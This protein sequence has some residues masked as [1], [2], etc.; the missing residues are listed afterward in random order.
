MGNVGLANIGQD[1]LNLQNPALLPFNRNVNIEGGYHLQRKFFENEVSSSNR[2]G[3]G[4][5]HLSI[6]LPLTKK[7]TAAFGIKPFSA[8]EYKFYAPVSSPF[9]TAVSI[10][11]FQKMQ[12]TLS[13]VFLAGGVQLAK[14]FNIGMEASYIFGTFTQTDSIIVAYQNF[15]GSQY[16]IDR[17]TLFKGLM[18]RPGFSYVVPINKEKLTSLVI[19]GTVQMMPALQAKNYETAFRPFGIDTINAGTTSS[20]QYPVNYGLGIAFQRSF[21]FRLAGD[22]KYIAASGRKI[23]YTTSAVNNGWQIGLGTEYIPGTSKS[24]RYVNI[25]NYRAGVQFSNLPYTVGNESIQSQLLTLGA[26]FPI[27]RKESKFMRPLFNVAFQVGQMGNANSF[28]GRDRY[29]GL[30]LGVTLN[31]QLWFQRYRID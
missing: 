3:G 13:Q 23:P 2:W 14:N 6:G 25:I 5:L 30:V 24:T 31:D 8:K 10:S 1:H 9:D 15:F 18:I 20:F 29:I 21:N 11:S 17:A 26:S 12:G 19:G 27:I 22:F 28:E 4:P 7:A 16:A